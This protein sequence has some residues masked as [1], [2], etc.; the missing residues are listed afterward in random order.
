[1]TIKKYKDRRARE[2]EK[3]FM[4]ALMELLKEKPLN[5]ISVMEFTK[6]SNISRSTFYRHYHE[7]AELKSEM[8]DELVWEFQQSIQNYQPPFST[9][10]MRILCIRILQF[11]VTH[12]E[13]CMAFFRQENGEIRM[14]KIQKVLLDT[15]TL[16]EAHLNKMDQF[17]IIFIFTGLVNVL[18][19]WLEGKRPVAVNDLVDYMVGSINTGFH[20]IE[21]PPEE[22]DIV[23]EFFKSMAGNED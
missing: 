1:M 21:K 16:P 15:F 2:T 18:Q 5:H 20:F 3:I 6:R 13:E 7:L 9:E 22:P 4:A 23:A 10:Q 8:E 12:Y 19:F 14:E 11:I 17:G